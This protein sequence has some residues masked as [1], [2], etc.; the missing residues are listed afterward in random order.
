MSRQES[1]GSLATP[2]SENPIATA[3]LGLASTRGRQPRPPTP[4]RVRTGGGSRRRRPL[5]LRDTTHSRLLDLAVWGNGGRHLRPQVVARHRR[6]R[7]RR[8]AVRARPLDVR[9]AALGRGRA[10]ADRARAQGGRRRDDPPDDPDRLPLRPSPTAYKPASI[11]G[12]LSTRSPAASS[13]VPS[14]PRSCSSRPHG[15]D[16]RAGRCRWWAARSSSPWR[17]SG[18]RAP[19]GISTT[20]NCP[21]RPGS[22]ACD[23]RSTRTHSTIR[24]ATLPT[25][26][27]PVRA[28]ATRSPR[29]PAASPHSYS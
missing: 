15:G 29:S 11:P 21:D 27:R 18:T 14:W 23:Q 16:C 2:E 4:Q 9:A 12:W 13:T 22:L 3:A 24:S 1:R 26:A 8:S 20:S 25:Q 17:C 10:A 7:L 6:T 5:H 28:G 19:S